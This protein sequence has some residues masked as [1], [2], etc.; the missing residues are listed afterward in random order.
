MLLIH[1]LG[2]VTRS[3]R[4]AQKQNEDTSSHN[5]SLLKKVSKSKEAN[6]EL[7]TCLKGTRQEM[8][9]T[10][11]VLFK[12]QHE[13][14][15]TKNASSLMEKQHLI[16]IAAMKKETEEAFERAKR[17]QSK[18]VSKSESKLAATERSYAK[19]LFKSELK[20][21]AAEIKHKREVMATEIK[22]K[23]DVTIITN[24][25]REDLTAKDDCHAL[26]LEEKDKEISV[27][28]SIDIIIALLLSVTI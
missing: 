7:R 4:E 14:T 9:I 2:I 8:R 21:S 12:T 5:K 25:A 15:A 16:R 20:L 6:D 1:R 3:C 28:P 26:E 18:I 11:S 22:H 24:I 23:R 27:S 17:V 13:I 19:S 10:K